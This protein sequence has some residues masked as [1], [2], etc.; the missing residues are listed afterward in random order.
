MAENRSSFANSLDS[1][2]VE[3]KMIAESHPDG[4]E[5]VK[6]MSLMPKNGNLLDRIVLL[7]FACRDAERKKI[8]D[9]G[10]MWWRAMGLSLRN[11]NGSSQK[12]LVY[13]ES[14][15]QLRQRIKK[16]FPQ[17]HAE[18]QENGSCGTANSI[19][20]KLSLLSCKTAISQ[21]LHMG[22]CC[23]IGSSIGII[24]AEEV[25]GLVRSD[26]KRHKI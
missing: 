17:A 20:S 19:L 24:T 4:N 22:Y 26:H 3:L 25:L 2:I 7:G 8:I 18:G 9:D 14:V 5:C 11:G 23:R 16:K 6:I 13:K 15:D 1:A 12:K 10:P 21:A